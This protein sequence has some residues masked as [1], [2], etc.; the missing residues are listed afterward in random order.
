MQK[1]KGKSVRRP[2]EIIDR[3]IKDV[4]LCVL[5]RAVYIALV[6]RYQ[7]VNYAGLQ[8]VMSVHK[9]S[10]WQPASH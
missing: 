3:S 10:Y 9:K 2:R 1:I 7:V 6:T 8:P 5:T 4:P